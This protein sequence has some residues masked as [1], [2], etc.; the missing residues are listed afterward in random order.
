MRKVDA[1]VWAGL[2]ML[3]VLLAIGLPV[4]TGVVSPELPRLWWSLTYVVTVVALV[5]AAAHSEP[6]HPPVSGRVALGVATVGA[7]VLVGSAPAGFLSI[8][9]VVVAALAVYLVPFGLVLA[10]VGLNT[11]LLVLAWA[12]ADGNGP[13]WE[14]VAA[15]ALYLFLQ[16]VSALSVL[17]LVREQ[18][19]RRELTAAHVELRAATALLG[20]SARTAERLRISRD[21]HDTV[22]H[23]LTVLSL[24]LEA[25]RHREGE[26]AQAHVVR[27]GAVARELLG[28]VR[29]AVDELR[30][31]PTDLREALEQVVHDIPG[32]EVRLEVAGDVEVGE[33]ESAAL[34][35]AVQEIVTNTLRHAQ[36]RTLSVTVARDGEGCTVLQAQ[37]DGRGAAR[38]QPGHGLQGLVERFEALGGEVRFDGQGPAGFAVVARVPA[39]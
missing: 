1:E 7:W 3:A 19:L 34:V 10:I 4:L 39:A 29:A 13:W 5:V 32:L 12:W 37:D 2:V 31:R 8:L 9:L 27:A 26:G 6:G 18:R 22:G 24:E 35:R 23:S 28:D 38:V 30:T 33:E 20:E 25:A 15:A 17:S 11:A 36:A 21:L 16:I 14:V